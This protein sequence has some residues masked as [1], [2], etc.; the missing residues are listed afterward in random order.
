[1][2]RHDKVKIN[3]AIGQTGG[4][5]RSS[6]FVLIAFIS[7]GLFNI[8]HPSPPEENSTQKKRMTPQLPGGWPEHEKSRGQNLPPLK[9]YC[10]CS[11]FVVPAFISFGVFKI[12]RGRSPTHLLHSVPYTDPRPR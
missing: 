3:R 8:F 9:Y 11:T 4:K 10:C 2:P 6:S 7:F 1:M 5:H 12:L